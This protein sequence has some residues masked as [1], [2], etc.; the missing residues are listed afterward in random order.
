MFIYPYVTIFQVRL[1]SGLCALAQQR[2]PAK[3]VRARRE[4]KKQTAG[5]NIALLLLG[6]G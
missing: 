2:L 6:H 4:A 1:L 3:R 5:H